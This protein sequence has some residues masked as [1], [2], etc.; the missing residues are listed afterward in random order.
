MLPEL[1]ETGETHRMQGPVGPTSAARAKCVRD[2]AWQQ[3]KARAGRRRTDG[4]TGGRTDGQADRRPGGRAG[5]RAGGKQ[6]TA[7]GRAEP[8]AGTKVTAGQGTDTKKHG[9]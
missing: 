5:G 6:R 8:T 9:K 7:R 2:K 3:K 4:R 1:G